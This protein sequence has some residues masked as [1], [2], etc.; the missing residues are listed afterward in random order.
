VELVRRMRE[1]TSAS[2]RFVY[3]IML[4]ARTETADLVQGFEAG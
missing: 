1:E 2:G 3:V 4:T